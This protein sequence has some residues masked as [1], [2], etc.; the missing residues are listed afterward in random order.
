MQKRGQRQDRR[1]MKGPSYKNPEMQEIAEKMVSLKNR[2]ANAGV[3][4]HELFNDSFLL[5]AQLGDAR[6]K[7]RGQEEI[8]VA[9]YKS[10][11]GQQD[12]KAAYGEG[13]VG[14]VSK[15]GAHHKDDPNDTELDPAILAMLHPELSS[16]DQD[17]TLCRDL[18]STHFDPR[19]IDMRLLR[20]LIKNI[21]HGGEAQWNLREHDLDAAEVPEGIRALL[22]LDLLAN[23]ARMFMK[24]WLKE[25][26]RPDPY[27]PPDYLSGKQAEE[28]YTKKL[29]SIIKPKG[30]KIAYLKGLEERLSSMVDERAQNIYKDQAEEMMSLWRV[31]NYL[32][33]SKFSQGDVPEFRQSVYGALKDRG[34]EKAKTLIRPRMVR[35]DE[36]FTP[37][38]KH[39][40]NITEEEI[41]ASRMERGKTAKMTKDE[42]AEFE[43]QKKQKQE[44]EQLQ[45][46]QPYIGRTLYDTK[47]DRLMYC[48][49]FGKIS[50]VRKSYDAKKHV[51]VEKSSDVP[52]MEVRY[53]SRP[54]SGET[55]QARKENGLIGPGEFLACIAKN[56]YVVREDIPLSPDA[57]TID[58]NLFPLK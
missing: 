35:N 45:P 44:D 51:Y 30:F 7:E 38:A 4:I 47:N 41:K 24:N 58:A 40:F 54:K 15:K 12:V 21:E 26:Q 20:S 5:P 52:A 8:L 42:K 50:R 13:K 17:V 55:A 43:W 31:V 16:D 57:T 19:A 25:N 14:D 3:S 11:W 39:T 32:I 33:S 18:L 49:G 1:A 56:Q 10:A 28:A 27:S 23:E 6:R 53:F 37:A 2:E 46:L 36:A 34:I 9:A 29:S 22:Y 48:I